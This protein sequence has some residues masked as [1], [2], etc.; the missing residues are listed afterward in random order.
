ME[1]CLNIFFNTRTRLRMA[2]VFKD[3]NVLGFWEITLAL[4]ALFLWFLKQSKY[5][6]HSRTQNFTFE[7]YPD[8]YPVK[9][10]LVH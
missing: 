5:P 1:L 8:N 9:T 6:G 2:C 4:D 7:A 10:L 3:I